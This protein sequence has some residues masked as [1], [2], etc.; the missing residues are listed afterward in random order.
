MLSK[1][2][3][4]QSLFFVALAFVSLGCRG[5]SDSEPTPT[6]GAQTLETK[7]GLFS[8]SYSTE[9]EPPPLH[10]IHEWILTVQSKEGTPVDGANILVDGDMPEHQHG[11]PTQ[12]EVTEDLGSGRY[13]VE[14][15]KFSM[16][17][18]WTVTIFV[19]AEG[20]YDEATFE[21]NL[22]PP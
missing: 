18:Y 11:L 2:L 14:G 10:Q 3:L 5:N 4:S 22:D 9:I 21:L 13:R 12:P 16:P 15:M 19:Q 7:N 1:K 6:Q 20:Q 17:G 8:V